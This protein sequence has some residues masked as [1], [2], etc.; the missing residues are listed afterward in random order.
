MLA[1]AV[2]L[3]EVEHADFEHE[4]V[5]RAALEQALVRLFSP[6]AETLQRL[7]A[8]VGEEA[9]QRVSLH[10]V[11]ATVNEHLDREGRVALLRH[12]WEVAYADGELHPNEEH[13]I[14]RLA[15]LMHLPHSDFIR[16]RLSVTDS[17]S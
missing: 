3:F 10:D 17:V 16:T 5:E 9:E 8:K 15:D 1:A 4:H 13:A 2:L 12:F 7:V 11:I 6:D 14:R